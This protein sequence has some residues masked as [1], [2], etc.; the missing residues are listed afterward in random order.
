MNWAADKP[1]SIV[2][3][4]SGWGRKACVLIGLVEGTGSGEGCVMGQL[5][6]ENH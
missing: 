6:D 5:S 2:C 1:P 3:G 4:A